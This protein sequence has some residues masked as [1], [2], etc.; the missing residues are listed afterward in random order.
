[1]LDGTPPSHFDE[2]FTG[3]VAELNA[4]GA[5]DGLHRLDGR[6]LI[7]LD[8]TEYF[9]S[10]TIHCPNCSTRKRNHGETEYFHQLLAATLVAPGRNLALPLPPEFLAPREGPDKQD[11][12]RRRQTLARPRRPPMRRA[13]PGIPRRRPVRLPTHL[14]GHPRQRRTLPAQRQARQPQNTS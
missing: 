1:M 9:R 10:G 7:A 3:L 2:L 12:E 6:T 8:G 4:S 5:L 13:P 11:C 14:P